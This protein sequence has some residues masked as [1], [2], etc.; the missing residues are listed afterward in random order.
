MSRVSLPGRAHW[1]RPP[2][3]ERGAGELTS[4]PDR[5]AMSAASWNVVRAVEVARLVRTSPSASSVS[6]WCRRRRCRRGPSPR[7][8]SGT[9]GRPPRRRA[10][11][12][13]GRR[14]PGV[15]DRL[16]PNRRVVDRDARPGDGRLDVVEG[17]LREV[18]V[19][20]AGRTCPRARPRCA[21][22]AA[23]AAPAKARRTGSREPDHA[24][25]DSDRGRRPPAAAGR[26]RS[27][28][29]RCRAPVLRPM[30][31]TRRKRVHAE[32][33]PEG[34]AEAQALD[35]GRAEVPD[36]RAMTAW[37]PAGMA[38]R[39]SSALADVVEAP[40]ADSSRMASPTNSGLPFVARHTA[41]AIRSR[42]RSPRSP[43]TS[44]TASASRPAQRD[45]SR[46]GSRASSA[47]AGRQRMLRGQL[48]VAVGADDQQTHVAELARRGTGAARS[49]GVSAACRSS[50]TIRDRAFGAAWR[51]KR[52]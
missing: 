19:G 38:T 3:P 35:R 39:S 21:G 41:A 20:R 27:P 51:R 7:A 8:P 36:R 34:R 25:T 24:R 26:P 5:R 4:I 33:G 31:P 46:P 11:R 10:P 44:A 43:M 6:V 18:L 22:G 48:D 16:S 47:M 42:A 49:T 17:E 23:P 30:S 15:L 29:R 45:H 37:T 28:R 40:S 52:P 13:P 50:R 9:A 1:W 12:S 14:P 32:L 2:E